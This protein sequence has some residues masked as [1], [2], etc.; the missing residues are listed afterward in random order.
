M[1]SA[2]PKTPAMIDSMRSD[3]AKMVERLYRPLAEQLDLTPQQR[4]A[5]YEALLENKMSGIAQRAALL[6][7]CDTSR[8]AETAAQLQKE[9]D[10]RLLALL[11]E[12]KFGQYQQYQID[13][14]DR[15]VLVMIQSDFSEHPLTQEQY[16]GL[17]RA[18]S[19]ARKTAKKGGTNAGFSI[20]DSGAVMNQKL[21]RQASIDQQVSKEAAAFLSPAQLQILKA[22]QVRL[23]GWRKDGYAKAQEMFG[24]RAS[25]QESNLDKAR[26]ST[27]AK[28][29]L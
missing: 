17:L 13:V 28:S 12:A 27:K 8:L 14:G 24:D 1:A 2:M 18:M 20:A 19:S 22:A 9:T 6:S 4:E 16:L 21:K 23:R 25:P 29:R 5:F 7:H 11:G 3:A 15:G 10:G 26:G